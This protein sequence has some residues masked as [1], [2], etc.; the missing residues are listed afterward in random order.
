M[1]SNAAKKVVVSRS[2]IGGEL[3]I[4]ASEILDNCLYSGFFGTLDYARIKSITDTVMSFTESKDLEMIIIDLSNVDIID[5][6]VAVHLISIGETLKLVGVEII[7]CGMKPFIA[8]SIIK[9]GVSISG[10]TFT[11]NLKTALQ[12]ALKRSGLKILPIKD[13]Y[14]GI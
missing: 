9:T 1:E 12:E 10:F 5:S 4:V 6:A 8:Q 13:E 11:K 7:F 14:E 2:K 3:P